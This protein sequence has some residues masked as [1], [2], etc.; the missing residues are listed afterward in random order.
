[1][2][3]VVLR[4]N[5]NNLLQGMKPMT[6]KTRTQVV[7][8]RA[9]VLGTYHHPCRE[10]RGGK[11]SPRGG[12]RG[13][14]FSGE[15][16]GQGGADDGDPRGGGGARRERE[17][18]GVYGWFLRENPHP[19]PLLLNTNHRG[20][21]FRPIVGRNSGPPEIPA[22]RGGNSGLPGIHVFL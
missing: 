11:G 18:S 5:T 20:W 4:D 17:R 19:D 14:G 3:L 6:T 22:P 8:P 21:K 12:G 16:G 15:S 9:Q 2:S 10:M 7:T 13:P 1:M